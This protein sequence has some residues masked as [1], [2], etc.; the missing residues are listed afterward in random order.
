MDI[1]LWQSA[2]ARGI[3]RMKAVGW[4]NKEEAG[5]GSFDL[6]LLIMRLGDLGE[7]FHIVAKSL[8]HKR[9]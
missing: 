7:I 3:C 4:A 5:V 8:V 2:K 6:R 1:I 9:L